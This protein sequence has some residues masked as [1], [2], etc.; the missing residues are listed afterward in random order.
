MD[1]GAN[2]FQLGGEADHVLG[3]TPPRHARVIAG[4]VGQHQVPTVRRELPGNAGAD[5][6]QPSHTR[7]QGN[8]AGSG[9]CDRFHR[10]S[11]AAAVAPLVQAA[12][13]STSPVLVPSVRCRRMVALMTAAMVHM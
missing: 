4:P 12:A 9:G 3:F 7:D 13:G 10:T 8:G 11:L 2:G 5:A 6:S 1:L